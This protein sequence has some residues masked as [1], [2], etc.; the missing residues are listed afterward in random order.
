MET[1]L[2]MPPS[3]FEYDTICRISGLNGQA[4]NRDGLKCTLP[5]A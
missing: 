4:V 5:T 2:L 3:L 1:S